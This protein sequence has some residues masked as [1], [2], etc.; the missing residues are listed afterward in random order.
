MGTIIK[1]EGERKE[2]DDETIHGEIREI[3]KSVKHMLGKAVDRQHTTNLTKEDIQGKK[4]ALQDK[5]KVFLPADKGRV[6]WMFGLTYCEFEGEHY[7]LESGPIGLGAT[8]EIAIIYMEE[9]QIRAT[10]TSPS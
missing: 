5:N 4:K 1:K 3:R 8:G 9:F 7:V 10:K 6:E 2:I